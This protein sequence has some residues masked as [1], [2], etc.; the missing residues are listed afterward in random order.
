L[1]RKD[2]EYMW[3][4]KGWTGWG[5]VWLENGRSAEATK[6]YLAFNLLVVI[7]P[8]RPRHHRE[9]CELMKCKSMNNI[10]R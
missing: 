3:T 10:Y 7:E 8:R 4:T 9:S 1:L 6:D 2:Q 5:K